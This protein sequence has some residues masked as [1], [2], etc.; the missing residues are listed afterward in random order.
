[1]SGEQGWGDDVPKGKVT[2]VQG[3]DPGDAMRVLC[4]GAVGLLK[5][6]VSVIQFRPWSVVGLM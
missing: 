4:C 2:D 6:R 3:A 1:M 5:I